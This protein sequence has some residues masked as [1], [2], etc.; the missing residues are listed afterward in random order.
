[1]ENHP[2]LLGVD[3]VQARAT[4]EASTEAG[5][6]LSK[7]DLAQAFIAFFGGYV[8]GRQ[9]SSASALVGRGLSANGGVVDNLIV[10][11]LVRV[12]E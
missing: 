10:D 9:P 1:M 7:A 5:H 4:R 12:A 11:G 3:G 8:L 6:A 2:G